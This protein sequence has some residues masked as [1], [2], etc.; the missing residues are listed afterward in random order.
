MDLWR[1]LEVLGWEGGV[2]ETV[3]TVVDCMDRSK[4]RRQQQRSWRNQRRHGKLAK[5][6]RMSSAQRVPWSDL[7]PHIC[8]TYHRSFL[9]S[10]VFVL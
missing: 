6:C 10:Y 8:Q 2:E 7:N 1:G 5:K 9:R 4:W 3:R